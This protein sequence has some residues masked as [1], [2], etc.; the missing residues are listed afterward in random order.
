MQ[1]NEQVMSDAM[2]IRTSIEYAIRNIFDIP[3]DRKN[4]GTNINRLKKSF[5]IS[6]EEQNKI[7]KVWDISSEILHLNQ[8]DDLKND[9]KEEVLKILRNIMTKSS[10]EK[11][12]YDINGN[13]YY[14]LVF[15]KKLMKQLKQKK[16][17]YNANPRTKSEMN[18]MQWTYAQNIF[19]EFIYNDIFVPKQS[20]DNLESYQKK[21]DCFILARHKDGYTQTV[22]LSLKESF[23]V[24]KLFICSD[25]MYDDLYN[26]EIDNNCIGILVE[27]EC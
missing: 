26:K 23:D 21:F 25:K 24:N 10:D 22:G 13:I 1:I 7:K 4:I 20:F 27:I 8:Q 17:Q 14:K 6:D 15:N 11:K 19:C 16:I 2:T 12:E 3:Q 5:G 18:A 9:D